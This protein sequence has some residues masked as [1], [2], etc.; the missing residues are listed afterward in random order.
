MD[1]WVVPQHGLYT[2]SGA[3]TARAGPGHH[4]L[5]LTPVQVEG[6][7]AQAPGT[8]DPAPGQ[9]L[10]ATMLTGRRGGRTTE[11]ASSRR[12]GSGQER[13]PSTALP[14]SVPILC[15]QP[16]RTAGSGL[17]GFVGLG[18]GLQG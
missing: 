8:A 5:H 17:S 12:S 11:P 4:Q 1:P 13:A 16:K 14:S 2:L 15:W 3:G 7:W 18:D 10:V 9:L 6:R